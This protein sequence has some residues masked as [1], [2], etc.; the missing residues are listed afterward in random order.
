MFSRLVCSSTWVQKD[1]AVHHL[2]SSLCCK[3]ND[4]VDA[5][6]GAPSSISFQAA[7]HGVLVGEAV[8]ELHTALPPLPRARTRAVCDRL[9]AALSGWMEE[10]T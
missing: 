1:S 3:M 9:V 2:A 7:I 10:Q 6:A 5:L 8:L 4:C